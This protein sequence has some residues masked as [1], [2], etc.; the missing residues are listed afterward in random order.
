VAKDS[1]R[2]TAGELQKI[3]ESRD[4][5]TIIYIYIY[6]H[7]HF[8]IFP[9]FQFLLSKEMLDFCDLKKIKDQKD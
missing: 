9:H 7:I 2:T 1:P 5:K 4:Q 6:I 8:N 3:V